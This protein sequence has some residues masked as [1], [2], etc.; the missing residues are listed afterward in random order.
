MKID[1]LSVHS[2]GLK[3]S[4]SGGVNSPLIT[5]SA[6][7]YIR[8]SQV[9]YP[10]YFNTPNQKAVGA[11]I[12]ALEGAQAGKVFSSGM[13]AISTSMFAFLH[14]GDHVVLQRN[15]YGGTT[16]LVNRMFRQFG[17]NFSYVDPEPE[18][19]AAACRP[20]TRL[21]Y[22]ETP[23]NPHLYL[24][25]VKAVAR[26]AQERGVTTMIDNTFASPINQQPLDLGM[27]ISIHSGTKY[28][29]GHSDLSCGAV[30]TSNRLMEDIQQ[31]SITLGG[32]LDA[33]ACHLLERSLKTLPLRVRR[34]NEVATSLANF[35]VAHP[36]IARV[37]YPGLESHPQHDLAREQM[38]G[39]GGML[40]FDLAAHAPDAD[41]FQ[42]NLKLIKPA[43]SLGGVETTICSP[44]LT[45]HAKLTEEER[46]AQNITDRM[47][48]LSAGIEAPEDLIHDLKQALEGAT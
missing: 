21:I 23:S 45:S 8:Q 6:F 9:S 22:I 19:I 16:Y 24:V 15:L 35:L 34:Q 3:D 1:S 43:V 20:E 11:K 18:A 32:N 39:F 26:V 40:S 47:L 17:I 29:G 2:G 13:A 28:L 41:T 33:Q 12:A 4:M 10:R 27:D 36:H 44:V 31:A 42:R 14:T 48:R 25:D 7:D 46:Q 37:N 5:S 38:L 30:A